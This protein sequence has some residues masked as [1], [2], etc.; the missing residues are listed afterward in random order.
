MT[1]TNSAWRTLG[2][3]VEGDGT[4]FSLFSTTAQR[5]R[6]A[7]TLM[8]LSLPMTPL[9]FQGQEWAASTPSLATKAVSGN[10][11]RPSAHSP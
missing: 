4:R 5:C 11:G 6:C 3:H 2:A 9:L 1:Q 8:L 7:S 10:L